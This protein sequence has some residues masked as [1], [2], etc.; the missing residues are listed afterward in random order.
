[1]SKQI[2]KYICFEN[3]E[4]YLEISLNNIYEQS[5]SIGSIYEDFNSSKLEILKYLVKLRLIKNRMLY[6]A[7]TSYMNLVKCKSIDGYA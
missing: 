1:M 3:E 5:F 4:E 7:C 2:R 6:E